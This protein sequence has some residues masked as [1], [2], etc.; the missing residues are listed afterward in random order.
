[1]HAIRSLGLALLAA[2]LRASAGP[3]TKRSAAYY[4]PADKGGS[5]LT[6]VINSTLGEPLNVRISRSLSAQTRVDAPCCA[7]HHLRLE[8]PGRAHA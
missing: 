2:A 6:Q 5:M 7:G 3:L 8:L 4:N 1:M